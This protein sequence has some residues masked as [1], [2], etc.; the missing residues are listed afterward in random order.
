MNPLTIPPIA[1]VDVV[2][3]EALLAK[4]A[5]QE[6]LQGVVAITSQSEMDDAVAAASLAKGLLRDMEAVRTELKAP[7]LEAG[8]AIDAIASGYCD[9]LT[10][11][12]ARVERLAAS[13]QSEKQREADAERQRILAPA[14]GSGD[15][16]AL[17]EAH[18][19]AL[20][21]P[22]P[23]AKGAT[24]RVSWDYSLVS[25][26]DLY[27]HNPMLCRLE[28]NRSAILGLLGTSDTWEPDSIPGLL[29]ERTTK[30]H[31]KA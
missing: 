18:T 31:A 12:V 29:L 22:E 28:P 10:T 17:R 9:G 11:D 7:V 6:L 26:G 2:M 1:I 16:T 30:L 14:A 19:A 23:K 15:V 4:K 8:R 5:A 24:V 27:Q 20:A 13:W 3:P 21:V 25:A